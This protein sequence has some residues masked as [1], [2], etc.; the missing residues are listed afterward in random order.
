MKA[1]ALDTVA[2]RLKFGQLHKGEGREREKQVFG[3]SSQL[4]ELAAGNSALIKA[5]KTH[6]IAGFVLDDLCNL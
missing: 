6:H 4:I 2:F 1:E 5:V 3:Q